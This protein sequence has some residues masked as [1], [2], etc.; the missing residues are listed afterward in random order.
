MLGFIL[1]SKIILNLAVWLSWVGHMGWG[2]ASFSIPLSTIFLQIIWELPWTSFGFV[3]GYM[4]LAGDCMHRNI[5]LLLAFGIMQNPWWVMFG[6]TYGLCF[7]LPDEIKW[8]LCFFHF[9]HKHVHSL[10]DY[11]LKYKLGETFV[12]SGWVPHEGKR[13]C[14]GCGWFQRRIRIYLKIY[15]CWPIGCKIVCCTAWLFGGIDGWPSPCNLILKDFLQE[16][17]ISHAVS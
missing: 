15:F 4:V 14:S 10:L 9:L 11:Q 2:E 7:E 8:L 5:K 16:Y 13:Y 17:K 3:L 12:K 1:L 6:T